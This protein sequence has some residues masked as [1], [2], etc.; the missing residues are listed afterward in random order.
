MST[1]RH[2]VQDYI[3]MRRR[4]GF[5]LRETERGLI[6]FVTF[7][8]DNDTP[9][10]TTELALAWAQRPSHLQPSSWAKRLRDVR[11]F[12]RHRSAADPRTQIPPGGLLPFRPK[13]A[14]AYLYSKEEIERL[15]AATL[16]MPCRYAHCKLRPWTY[17]CL[18]GLLSVTGL[19]L[20]EARNLK[21]SDVDLDAA[22]LTIRGTKF[23]KTRVVPMHASTCIV[24]RNYVKRRQ[25]YCAA[26][27]ASPYLFTS[28]LGNRLDVGAIH[29]TFYALSRQI[30][31]RGL[32]ESHGPRLHD[33]RH[34]FATNTL[35]HWYEAGQ[36]PERLLPILSTYLGHVHVA[37]TQWYLSGSPELMKEAMRRL[38]YRWEDRT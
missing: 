16:E 1:L 17:Y 2:A 36:D 23:G 14:R 10:I 5:K 21:L 38:E 27:A 8:E 20:G 3:E 26:Q 11:V 25:Q 24:L 22:V 4:L 30:G 9:Y 33:M 37:D 12:A 6:D 35:V 7:L 32:N 28:K 18:F 34:V 19:R 29:R 15:L 31:L 13:R